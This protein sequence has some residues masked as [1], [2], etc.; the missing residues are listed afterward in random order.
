MSEVLGERE[1]TTAPIRRRWMVARSRAK[2]RSIVSSYK[3]LVSQP[4]TPCRG[5]FR[6]RQIEKGFP[7]AEFFPKDISR[8]KVSSSREYTRANRAGG[9]LS[10]HVCVCGNFPHTSHVIYILHTSFVANVALTALPFPF[11]H[12]C[13]CPP[14]LC[15][16]DIIS[17][18][19]N[20]RFPSLLNP[21][22]GPTR[23]DSIGDA[24]L[25]AL[26]L[27]YMSRF[28]A[29]RCTTTG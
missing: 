17:L 18:L 22:V 15:P 3:V 13:S 29:K 24:L 19:N 20:S 28:T 14:P 11:A 6:E 7:V 27:Q 9:H 12:I 25:F 23:S 26:R 16:I 5:C 2:N 10:S 1:A 21:N 8:K 4:P